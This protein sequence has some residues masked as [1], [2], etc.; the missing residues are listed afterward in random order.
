LLTNFE[1]GGHKLLQIILSGQPELATHLRT[2]NGRALHQRIAVRCHLQPLTLAETDAYLQARLE[3]A[4]ADRRVFDAAAVQRIH[5]LTLGVPRVINVI[6]DHC[7]LAGFTAQARTVGRG[8]VEKVGVQL[9]ISPLRTA[10][11]AVGPQ[12]A[13]PAAADAAANARPPALQRFASGWARWAGLTEG[14]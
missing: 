14:K 4:G 2:V 11:A 5:E 3:Q 7:L 13:A 6:A 9:Q 12:A 8:L 10:P 1:A